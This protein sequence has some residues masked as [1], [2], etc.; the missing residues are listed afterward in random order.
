MT[1]FERMTAPF[2]TLLTP[3]MAAHYTATGYWGTDTLYAVAARH[4]AATPDAFAVR[5]R[6][7]RLTYRQLVAAADRLAAY[8]AGHGVRPGERVAVWLP[9]CVEVA[10]AL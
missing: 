3:S 6:Y 10:A 5:D 8:L 1:V 4:A 7:R 2:L 9:S